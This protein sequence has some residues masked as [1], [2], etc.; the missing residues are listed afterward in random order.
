MNRLFLNM[1]YSRGGSI[2]KIHKISFCTTC[3][4]RLDDLMIT[5]PANINANE[6]YPDLEFVLLDYNSS[7]GLGGWIRNKM[8][9]HIKSGR[10]VYYRTEE[11]THYSMTHSRNVAFKLATGD[12]VNSLDADNFTFDGK[13]MA[14][15]WAS[16]LNKQANENPENVV[17][18]KTRQ[19]TI[20]HGR[21]GFYK[22]EFMEL[23]GYNED[24]KGYGFD[25]QDLVER[26]IRLGFKLIKWGGGYF[27][28]IQTPPDKKDSNLSGHWDTM[29]RENRALSQRNL[30]DGKFIA[31]C[32][33]HWGKATVIRN[34]KEKVEI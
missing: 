12:I 3:M 29:R 7:D 6:D 31:N 18:C 5:L 21:I 34:F 15:S 1:K 11:P 25:D 28:R 33:K 14:M 23:G 32:G 8:M 26:A 10:L 17:F 19:V 24:I 9:R 4:N 13:P 2:A 30:A 16:W 20:L 27:Y 22:R